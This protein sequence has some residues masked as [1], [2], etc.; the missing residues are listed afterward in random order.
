MSHGFIPE[1]GTNGDDVF[2]LTSS[3]ELIFAGAG[4]DLVDG[5]V[6]SEGGNR[7][8]LGSGADI[9]VLGQG[10]RYNGGSGKDQ[11]FATEGGGNVITGGRGADQFWITTG[12]FISEVYT[13]T[14]SEG[15]YTFGGN[16]SSNSD[17]RLLSDKAT[18]IGFPGLDTNS[19]LNFEGIPTSTKRS[20]ILSMTLELEHDIALTELSSLIPATDERP[21]NVS[22]YGFKRG[23]E[24]DSTSGN[25]ADIKF[26][27]MGSKAVA[28]ELVGSSGVYEFDVSGLISQISQSGELNVGVSGVFGNIDTDGR[29][30]YA[31]FH[32]VDALLG[33]EPVLVFEI[34]TVNT[35]TDFKSGKDVIGLAGLELEFEDISVMQVKSDTLISVDGRDLALLE[36]VVAADLSEDDFIF[37]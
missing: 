14:A 1:F 22:I 25:D 21:V 36:N 34:E 27:R 37:A 29:N 2:E 32:P 31:S 15:Y 30:S 28:T 8:N 19:F 10:D 12:D 16:V 9:G 7:I 26:G 33:A 35:I 23:V 4:S 11:F 24:F 6:G 13:V 5:S 17:V 18:A 20:D 3:H